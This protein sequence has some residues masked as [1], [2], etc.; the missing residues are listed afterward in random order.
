MEEKILT[1][2]PEG[3][4]GVNISKA[5]YDQVKTAIVQSLTAKKSLTFKELSAAVGARLEGNFD[6]SVGWYCTTVK[7]DLEAKHIIE[8]TRKGGKAQQIKLA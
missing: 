1:E 6:G 4:K 2:H 3:L 7:L 8:C 5:K